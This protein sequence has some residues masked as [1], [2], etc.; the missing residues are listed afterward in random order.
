[1]EDKEREQ[2]QEEALEAASE[3]IA[4][5]ATAD[6]NTDQE[7]ASPEGQPSEK[8]WANLFDSPEKLEQ[9]YG[10]IY[11]AFHAKSRELQETRQ[12][13]DNL[14]QSL[15]QQGAPQG[16]PFAQ[17]MWTEAQAASGGMNPAVMQAVAAAQQTA[18]EARDLGERFLVSSVESQ[19]NNFFKEH[20]ELGDTEEDFETFADEVAMFLG[21]LDVDALQKVPQAMERSYRII[22]YPEAVR[23]AR[24]KQ[25]QEERDAERF[26][27]EGSGAGSMSMP[28]NQSRETSFRKLVQ[29]L[30]T[31]SGL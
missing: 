8:K 11:R 25:E 20:P 21:E 15:S 3:S 5:T 6:S 28:R 17:P 7:G 23:E 22:H 16:L 13:L 27:V 30:K 9:A 29:R 14:V 24:R 2:L 1:M 19:V 12:A 31:E 26:E 18:Q 10:H 4:D